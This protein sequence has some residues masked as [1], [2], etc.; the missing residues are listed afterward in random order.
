MMR[1]GEEVPFYCLYLCHNDR[2]EC[3]MVESVG[4]FK[5]FLGAWPYEKG[6]VGPSG[7]KRLLSIEIFLEYDR[8]ERAER[9]DYSS[10]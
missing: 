5:I 1:S 8:S 3:E 9:M 6:A 10:D 4:K 7:R 2:R